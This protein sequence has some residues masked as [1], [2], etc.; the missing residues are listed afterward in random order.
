MS[1]SHLYTT[2]E[3]VDTTG[4]DPWGSL[5]TSWGF[6]PQQH[7]AVHQHYAEPVQQAK[8][9]GASSTIGGP[10]RFNSSQGKSAVRSYNGVSPKTQEQAQKSRAASA[11]NSSSPIA[12]AARVGSTSARNRCTP[13]N[14]KH[15][16]DMLKKVKIRKGAQITTMHPDP[17]LRR[18]LSHLL[19]GRRKIAV[20]IGT[21]VD[22]HVFV[23]DGRIR[24]WI[25]ISDISKRARSSIRRKQ[26]G[27]KLNK[28]NGAG[29]RAPAAKTKPLLRVQPYGDPMEDSV[30]HSFRASGARKQKDG[31]KGRNPPAGTPIGNYANSQHSQNYRSN[32]VVG[33]WNTPGA[34]SREGKKYPGSGGVRAFVP[35][36][37]QHATKCNTFR[38]CKVP[39]QIARSTD[40]TPELKRRA[41][42]VYGYTKLGGQRVYM[43]MLSKWIYTKDD[44]TI[45]KGGNLRPMHKVANHQA[46]QRPT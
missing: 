23:Y 13:Y 42:F 28:G 24:G 20:D 33:T 43:W 6:A 44:G 32:V 27:L 5:H 12:K 45:L 8:A 30:Y 40:E 38:R 37:P 10:S 14:G 34:A 3:A 4:P 31:T 15:R 26:N 16:K 41:W 19:N 39:A 18:D 1:D 2:S 36:D 11:R 29:H 46:D 21:V 17:A 9:N 35:Y 25:R 22:G 7:P